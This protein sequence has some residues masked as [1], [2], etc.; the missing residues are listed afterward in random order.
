MSDA[1]IGCSHTFGEPVLK[2]VQR[3]VYTVDCGCGETRE[4]SRSYVDYARKEADSLPDSD[5][6]FRH[7]PLT[8][9][10]REQ[11]IKITGNAL[12]PRDC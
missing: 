10:T 12:K 7:V 6:C 4:F 5:S 8:F 11:L 2:T 9:F 3:E 1:G